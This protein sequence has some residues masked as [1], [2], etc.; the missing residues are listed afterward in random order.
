MRHHTSI[1]QRH[2]NIHN[3]CLHPKIA[4]KNTKKIIKNLVHEKKRLKISIPTK[5]RINKLL[6]NCVNDITIS[7]LDIFASHQTK[8]SA[9]ENPTEDGYTILTRR[10]SFKIYSDISA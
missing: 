8:I 7:I 6:L 5:I 2:N 1:L 10:G 4:R 3:G 9:I